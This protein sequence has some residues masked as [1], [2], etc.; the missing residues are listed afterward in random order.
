MTT[1]WKFKLGV[2][3]KD[4][5]TGMQGIVIGRLEYL[6][7]CK[8]YDVQPKMLKDGKRADNWW[9]DGNQL[10]KVGEA[11]RVRKTRTGGASSRTP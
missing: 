9:I 5:V 10:T 2:K 7:G 8:Q 4:S 3:V 11:V 1:K 6:N